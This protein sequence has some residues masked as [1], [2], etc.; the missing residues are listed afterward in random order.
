MNAKPDLSPSGWMGDT[1]RGASM[2]R[3][4][5]LGD[6]AASLREA[7]V[8]AGALLAS[9]DKALRQGQ[10]LA[11][12]EESIRLA[13]QRVYTL[14]TKLKAEQAAPV[15]VA[16]QRVRLDSGGY[17]SGGAYWGIGTPLYWAGSDDGT[18]DLWFRATSR[19][20]AKAHVRSLH[21]HANFYR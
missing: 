16:L 11:D 3:P 13:Y 6:T 14:R 12:S 1:R 7:E 21:P 19:D 17:D 10:S 15:K 20:A 2:G 9:R 5:K 8:N 18:I 4:S